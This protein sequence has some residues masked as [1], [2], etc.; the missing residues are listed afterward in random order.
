MKYLFVYK[1]DTWWLKIK[2]IEELTNYSEKTDG[3]WAKAFDSLIH[4]KEFYDGE[5]H[6][7]SLAY[8]I[9]NYG[10]KRG[11]NSIEAVADFRSQ[12]FDAQLDLLMEGYTLFINENGGYHCNFTGD[13]KETQFIWR[14]EFVFPNFSKDEI[15]IKSFPGGQHFYAYIGDMQV[16]DG[17]TLKWN[18]YEEAMKMAESVVTRA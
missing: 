3:R 13:E 10:A 9:G 16:R 5:E 17:D 12:I 6:A 8:V 11:M 14:E 4:S 1:N 18:T 7:S 2:T 15:R